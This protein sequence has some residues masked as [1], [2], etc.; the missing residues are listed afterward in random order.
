MTGHAERSGWILSTAPPLLTD[1]SEFERLHFR[2]D[3]IWYQ[4]DPR[5]LTLNARRGGRQV[6]TSAT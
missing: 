3:S 2:E 5:Q 6:G 4:R 1:W